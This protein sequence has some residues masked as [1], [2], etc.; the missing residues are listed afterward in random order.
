MSYTYRHEDLVDLDVSATA[1]DLGDVELRTGDGFV[2]TLDPEKI[3]AL[4]R[5][6]TAAMR[7]TQKG[8]QAK[9]SVLHNRKAVDAKP[10]K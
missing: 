8:A 9:E 2:L 7:K 10:K 6:L 1:T 3:P 4:V 5:V